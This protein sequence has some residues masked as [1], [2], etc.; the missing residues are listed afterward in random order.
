MEEQPNGTATTPAKA[1]KKPNSPKAPGTSLRTAVAEVTK[2]YQAYSHGT[3][4]RGE[5]AN[6]LGMSSGSGAFMGKAATLKEYG[7]I[8][9]TGGSARVSDLFKAIL[10]A[11]IGSNELKR[12][13]LQAVRTPAVFARLLAQFGSKVPD[14]GV[15]ALRLETQERFN[16]E[17][18]AAVATALRT[19][20]AE[21]ALIDGNGNLLPV[22]EDA[23]DAKREED[24]DDGQDEQASPLAPSIP[25]AVGMSRVEVPLGA[26]RKA[27]IALPDDLTQA[28]KTKICA[29][30]EAYAIAA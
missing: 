20:L 16:R 21:Y 5:M 22:R 11:P 26:G 15:I 19:S 29:I 6:A 7:L 9:E 17:R 1:K 3:F 23:A 25:P 10:S 2:I 24:D 8:D 27:I 13:A 4:Q 18:A 28:D 12:H 30:L 14:V